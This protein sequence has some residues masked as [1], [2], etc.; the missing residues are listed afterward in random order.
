MSIRKGSK[1]V[2]LVLI[3]TLK[4]VRISKKSIYILSIYIPEHILLAITGPKSMK[5]KRKI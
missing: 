1:Y 3:L 4:L 2:K 5:G